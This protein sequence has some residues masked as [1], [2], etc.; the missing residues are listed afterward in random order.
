[1]TGSEK[2]A[3]ATDDRMDASG[4]AAVRQYL[5]FMLRGEIY[6]LDISFVRE[7]I[8][9]KGVTEVPL[10]PDA[11]PG[12]LNVRGQVVPLLDLG[13]RLGAPRMRPTRRTSVVVVERRK[14]DATLI[15]GLIVDGVSQAIFVPDTQ[16]RAATTIGHRAW[17]DF[18]SALLK[19]ESGFV[20]VLQLDAALTLSGQ[21]EIE[22]ASPA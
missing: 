18:V 8:Q 4:D 10:A 17:A 19:L 15:V 12:V 1:M 5:T 9:Y 14:G 21:R 2:L 22:R 6:A 3:L 20:P 7:V 13:I 11:L 16:I